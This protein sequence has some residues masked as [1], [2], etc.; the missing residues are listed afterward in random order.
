MADTNLDKNI[1]TNE[2]VAELFDID[3]QSDSSDAGSRVPTWEQL[4]ALKD[5]MG[6]E[7]E[8][9]FIGDTGTYRISIPLLEQTKIAFV[10]VFSMDLLGYTKTLNNIF[11]IDT[12]SSKIVGT[13]PS[14]YGANYSDGV[15]S[16]NSN[17]I[18]T[19]TLFWYLVELNDYPTFE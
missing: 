5:N 3:V 9:K 17:E 14:Y 15:I 18:S 10:F 16:F 8:M 13:D 4:K 11:C 19:G 7:T 1:P 2:Q 12:T 6:G